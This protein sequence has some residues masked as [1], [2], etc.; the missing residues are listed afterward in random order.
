MCDCGLTPLG[1]LWPGDD[2]HLAASQ[3]TDTFAGACSLC[4]ID[5]ISGNANQFAGGN[6][7]HQAGG[8]NTIN[9]GQGQGTQLQCQGTQTQDICGPQGGR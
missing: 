5:H 6:N 1:G 4:S 2:L 7:A 9:S 3:L 8:F